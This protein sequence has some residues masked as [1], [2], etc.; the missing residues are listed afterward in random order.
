MMIQVLEFE[1]AEKDQLFN[2][3][4]SDE[5]DHKTRGDTDND[6]NDE[7][8]PPPTKKNKFRKQCSCN[9]SSSSFFEIYFNLNELFCIHLHIS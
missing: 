5:K 9:F 7:I 6:S 2:T 4:N 8:I 1:T 3:N